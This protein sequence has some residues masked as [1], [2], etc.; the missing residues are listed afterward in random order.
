MKQFLIILVLGFLLPNCIGHQS[1]P[2][3]VMDLKPYGI[4][5]TI[6]APADSTQIENFDLA[7]VKD[8]SITSTGATRYA[9]QIYAG[10]TR[11]Q[12]LMEQTFRQ[13]R[14]VRSNPDF[15][16]IVEQHKDGFI[17]E[18]KSMRLERYSFRYIHL[19]GDT[20]I[21]FTTALN[22]H[23]SLEEVQKMYNAVKQ[24]K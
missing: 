22:Q 3:K 18:V 24:K 16:K 6:F 12:K 7:G 19:V 2:W 5:A 8:L 10:K 21:V 17:Y 1:K 9:I 15:G 13:I 14:E 20:E 11:G 23:F 4:P